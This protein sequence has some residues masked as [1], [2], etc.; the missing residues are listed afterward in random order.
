MTTLNNDHH[1]DI[2]LILNNDHHTD[3]E[4]ILNNDH[5]TD[6]GLTWAGTRS[7]IRQDSIEFRERN[8]DDSS[9]RNSSWLSLP[10]DLRK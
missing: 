8:K 9:C 3:I 1:T 7:V 5:H 6:T 4:L 2:E 10:D